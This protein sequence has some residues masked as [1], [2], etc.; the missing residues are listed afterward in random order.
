MKN[1][2][3]KYVLAP[4]I[5]NINVFSDRNAFCI[6]EFF[7]TYKQFGEYIS[8]I[9]LSLKE[10]EKE[11]LYFG[12]VVNDDIETYA[13]IFALWLEG[14]AYVPLHPKQP[15]ERNV[16][17]ISQMNIQ[18][19]MDSSKETLYTEYEVVSTTELKFEN[20]LLNIDQYGEETSVYILF[21]SGSTGKPKG[22]MISQKIWVLLWSPFGI[23]V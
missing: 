8:K 21:T 23:Q 2:F 19:I 15:L 16:E 9:R 5:K 1:R 20:T 4:L 17:I 11:N 22:V 14:K 12:L 13:S 7:Y 10:L 18:K 3:T 6:N